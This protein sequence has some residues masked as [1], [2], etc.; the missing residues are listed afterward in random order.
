MPDIKEIETI[1][2]AGGNSTRLSGVDKLE[3]KIQDKT[4]LNIVIKDATEKIFVVGKKRS[5]SKNVQWVEDLTQ[6]G[7]PAVGVFSG[8]K[9]VKSE[10][11]LL[12]AGD[13]PFIGD[14]VKELCTKALKNGAWLVTPDGV[15][16]PLAS[17]VKSS[18]LRLALEE[19]G[20]VN[21]SLN[22]LLGK[23]DLIEIPVDKSVIQD[24]DTWA[25]V[26]KVLRGDV[27]MTD[28][29]L[30]NVA[31]NLGIDKEIL[32]T[33]KI[34]DLTREVA[35][36]IE[37]KAAP[38]TTFLLGYAAGKKDV[39]KEQLHE[40]ITKIENAVSQWKEKGND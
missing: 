4:V 33:D 1:I 29:W 36:N 6:N 28:G 16:Q 35:H 32:D 12:L 7:G 9:Y 21:V 40:L 19:S 10:Y 5:T 23:M 3:I 18:E 22:Q 11:V 8:L 15:G 30:K 24:L 13:Q 17:C 34:L 25:D 14:Y 2:V 20:G 38:L 27:D 26:A 39:S 31:Q 37:R